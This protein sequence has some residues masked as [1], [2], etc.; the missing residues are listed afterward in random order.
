MSFQYIGL[1]GTLSRYT[2]TEEE[3]TRNLQRLAD[4]NPRIA[5]ITDR[6]TQLGDEVVLDYAG[7]CD[8]EQFVGGTAQGQT[9]VLGS[10][11]F[12]PGFEER[13]L[14]KVPGEEVVVEVTFPT[15]YHAPE[16]AGK[17][18]QF[19]CTIHEIRVKTPSQLDDTFAREF[20]GCEDLAEMR[21]K[22]RQSLQDYADQRGEM[23]LQDQLLRQ[24]AQSLEMEIT[25]E[26]LDEALDAQMESLK[27]QLAQQGLDL[28]MYCSFLS[29]T[30][31]QLRQDNIPAA[32][33]AV[34]SQAAIDKIVELENL[35]AEESEIAQALAIISRQNHMTLEQLKE[36]YDAQLE[37][38]VI[39]S[40]L[41]GRVMSLIRDSAEI[42]VV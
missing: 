4:M 20:G 29:T 36:H 35:K 31:E 6:A 27:A 2:V 24:A 17:A 32:R 8:G 28:N 37:Q 41:T 14:D 30:P 21:E 9:L 39:H 34:R 23:D 26:Q 33:M 18:A 42:T 25:Q 7:F 22:M 11:A 12:I 1:T 40:V 3:I 13:L 38:A 15:E 19:R 10:G 16:L 5:K